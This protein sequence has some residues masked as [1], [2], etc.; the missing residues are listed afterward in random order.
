MNIEYKVNAPITSDKFI[1]LL[2]DSTLCESRTIHDRDCIS[3][4]NQIGSACK[5]ILL[6]HL[7]SSVS[8]QKNNRVHREPF[9]KTS[10]LFITKNRF[11]WSPQGYCQLNSSSVNCADNLLMKK[12]NIYAGYRYPSE[13]IS[14][15]VWLYHRFTL[16]FRDIEE[17]LAARGIVVSYE[18]IRQW[19]KKMVRF[20]VTK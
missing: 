2:E 3:L 7:L 1:E 14:H 11:G 4:F 10:A 20:T 18:T 15:A 12:S 5:N 19:C 9:S 8:Y 13:V 6:I 16:N 17:L